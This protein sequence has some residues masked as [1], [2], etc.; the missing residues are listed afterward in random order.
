MG[1]FKSQGLYYTYTPSLASSVEVATLQIII[2]SGVR[3]LEREVIL[4]INRI[5]LL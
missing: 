5:L 1:H 3:M 2:C 4:G